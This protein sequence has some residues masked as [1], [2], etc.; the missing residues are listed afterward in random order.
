MKT[1]AVRTVL[2][3]LLLV[4]FGY[5]NPADAVT[6]TSLVGDK[7][8]FGGLTADPVPTT[9]TWGGAGG[10]F[11]EDRRDISDPLFTDIWE[12][13]QTVGGPLVSPISM[14]FNYSLG[15]DIPVSAMFSIN[16]AGMSDARGPWDVVFNGNSIG[17]IGTFAASEDETFK[18]LSFAVDTSWLTGSDTVELVYLDTAP[19]GFAINFAELSIETSAIPEPATLLLLGIG[20]MGFAGIRRR[21]V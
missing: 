7:D 16:E 2:V 13:Q 10:L 15:L 12:F 4:G 14:T 17:N 3:L 8:G 19:E 6:I 5:A 9:G 18:L 21:K 11:P 20:L 1:T